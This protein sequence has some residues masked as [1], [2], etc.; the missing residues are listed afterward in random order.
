MVPQPTA[1]VTPSGVRDGDPPTLAAL[2]ERRGRA[3][4]AYCERVC[5]PGEAVAA[6]SDALA[7]FRRSVADANDPLSLDPEQALL[8]ATR[9]AAAAHAPAVGE[10]APRHGLLGRRGG[11]CAIVPEL[12]AA[13]ASGDLTDG[14]RTRLVRHLERCPACRPAEERFRTGELAYHEAPDIAPEQP[15][16]AQFMR[17]LLEAMPNRAAAP[18]VATR[19][20]TARN[21]AAAPPPPADDAADTPDPADS[22]PPPADPPAVEA[23]PAQPT[24]APTTLSWEASEVEAAIAR[25]AAAGNP[26]TRVLVPGAV[27]GGALALAIVGGGAFAKDDS[28]APIV[29][30]AAALPI[31]NLHAPRA[32]VTTP[33][34]HGVTAP[35]TKAK[36]AAGKTTKATTTTSTPAAAPTSTSGS[37]TTTTTKTTTTKS[38]RTPKATANAPTSATPA[39]DSAG[40]DSSGFQPST[41]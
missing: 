17:A 41:P 8:R 30:P 22:E 28:L 39:G 7:R 38:A 24:A 37:A 11:A 2:A 36:P 23:A 18:E 35:A 10:P 3:V 1:A 4:L 32:P 29:G 34:P 12:L 15:V 27:V 25:A 33:L 13:R 26:I 9:Y 40:A 20:G 19:N 5:A 16:T 6:A 21:G 14:D 31:P